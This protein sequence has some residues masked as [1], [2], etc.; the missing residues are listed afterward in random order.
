MDGYRKSYDISLLSQ[1]PCLSGLSPQSC[2]EEPAL[3]WV[4]A[5]GLSVLKPLT[6]SCWSDSLWQVGSL[7]RRPASPCFS[8]TPPNLS[9]GPLS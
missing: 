6:L 3:P 2:P 7:E 8:A 9:L 1:A 5:Q 4:S